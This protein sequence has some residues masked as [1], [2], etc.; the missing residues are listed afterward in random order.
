MS[1][2]RL[3]QGAL[4]NGRYSIQEVVGRGG[5]G[6]VY[7][8]LDTRLDIVVAVKEMTEKAVSSDERATAIRQFEREAKLLGQLQHV[9]LPRVTDYFV[10]DEH[11][12]LIMEY[13]LGETLETMLR[14]ANGH[15]LPLSNVLDWSVQIADV[16]AYLHGQSPP[17]V[18]RD[19]KP[20]NIMVQA[21]GTIK[22]I[23]FGIARRFTEGATKDTLLY[24]SPGYSPPEQYG[25]AQTDSR[26]DIYAFGATLHHLV[27]GRDPAPTPFKFPLIR[28]FDPMLPVALETLI[29]KCLEMEEERRIQSAEE[30]R[31]A[32]VH[33]RTA[34]M[35]AERSPAIGSAASGRVRTNGHGSGSA[36][37]RTA[38]PKV[39]S[40]RVQHA[41]D[42]A[43]I[44]RILVGVLLLVVT[45]ALGAYAYRKL[46]KQVPGRNGSPPITASAPPPS[47]VPKPVETERPAATGTIHLTTTPPGATIYADGKQVGKSPLEIANLSPGTHTLRYVAPDGS[48]LAEAVRDVEIVEGQ[49]PPVET[50]L[51]APPS[52]PAAQP[53]AVLD[54]VTPETVTGAT[55]DRTGVRITLNM[56]LVGGSGKQGIVGVFF[57][58]PDGKPIVPASGVN[59]FQSKDGQ[60]AVF[61]PFHAEADTVD[62]HEMRMFVPLGAFPP[63]TTYDKVLYRVETFLDDK[64]VAQSDLLPLVNKSAP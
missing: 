61:T 14:V 28:S 20:A 57:Y 58:G 29:S 10:E 16:L 63:D 26:S 38:A 17:I 62:F 52:A 42:V 43:L 33:I 44:R 19:V 36:S 22:L 11:W 4:L 18:F 13:V 37:R 8:A 12:Y 2:L 5:M 48:G 54:R 55:Q 30:V 40:T 41:H 15:P 56:R 39:V 35:L 64:L 32:L 47:A 7:K 6:T 9:N 24:G 45:A 27:T 46:P 59:G 49:N 25:R 1:S 3:E 60:L 23:D 50:P 51:S 53:G 21:D 31:D 34:N